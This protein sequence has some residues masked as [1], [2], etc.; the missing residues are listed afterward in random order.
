MLYKLSNKVH[1]IKDKKL[2][3]WDME[4]ENFF[5][6]TEDYMMGNGSKIKCVVAE[7]YITSLEI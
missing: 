3:E 6:K 4:K 1:D 7:N 5:I 2:M